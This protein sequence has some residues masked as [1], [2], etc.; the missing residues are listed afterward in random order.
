MDALYTWGQ[1]SDEAGSDTC[2]EVSVGPLSTV[3]PKH[4]KIADFLLKFGSWS[5]VF[6][7][8]FTFKE[9]PFGSIKIHPLPAKKTTQ[10]TIHF[11]REESQK[12]EL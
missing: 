10:N 12:L 1:L 7:G 5:R 8:L 3:P 9:S 11:L 6:W 4:E 2:K